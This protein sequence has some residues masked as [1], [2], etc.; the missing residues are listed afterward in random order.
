MLGGS[1][2]GS[3]SVPPSMERPPCSL[4]CCPD[5]CSVN[6]GGRA[7]L[8]W[9]CAWHGADSAAGDGVR[10]ARRRR[11][12]LPRAWQRL[13]IRYKRARH[14]FMLARG[15]SP[16]CQVAHWHFATGPAQFRPPSCMVHVG[17]GD[18]L[19]VHYMVR[20]RRASPVR[21]RRFNFSLALASSAPAQ[22][23]RLES[24]GRIFDSSLSRNQPIEFTLGAGHVIKA[25]ARLVAGPSAVRA[26]EPVLTAAHAAVGMGPGPE[27][28]VV[29][30]SLLRLPPQLCAAARAHPTVF[31]RAQ[32]G[33]AANTHSAAGPG[34]WQPGLP[35][36]HPAR[37]GPQL[38]GGAAVGQARRHLAR[39]PAGT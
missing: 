37:R 18:V 34:L 14:A 4:K 22:Q 36:A 7:R 26:A 12:R 1:A 8:D 6:T 5:Q 21:V 32:P 31:P 24:N 3:S 29:R 16:L 39:A 27:R 38:P 13:H 33:R 2:G 19:K 30:P 9:L 25:R 15:H 20:A 35:A 28:H 17:Y 23:G 11:K 10:I